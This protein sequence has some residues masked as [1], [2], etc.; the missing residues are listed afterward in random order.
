VVV[1]SAI[2]LE[3]RKTPLGWDKSGVFS[4]RRVD[5][6]VSLYLVTGPRRR[7]TLFVA[8]F[9]RIDLQ[10]EKRHH[11]RSRRGLIM[12]GAGI[13]IEILEGDLSLLI[14]HH[15][16]VDGF[17]LGLMRFVFPWLIGYLN[18]H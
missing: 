16:P 4:A 12:L 2:R 9:Q 8:R 11:R 14:G 7:H 6:D 13:E 17:E 3:E 18:G 10:R 15:R 5:L 1:A